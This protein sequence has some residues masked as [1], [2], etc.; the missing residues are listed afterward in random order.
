MHVSQCF[1]CYKTHNVHKARFQREMRPFN[2]FNVVF[3][4]IAFKRRETLVLALVSQI[5][6]ISLCL[7]IS[8]CIHCDKPD[9]VHKTRF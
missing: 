7:H 6:H 5:L 8:Q 2:A 1:H 9:N 3:A 4:E